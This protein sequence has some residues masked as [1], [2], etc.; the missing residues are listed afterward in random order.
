MVH[1]QA[2]AQLG[3]QFLHVGAQNKLPG[4]QNPADRL[5]HGF[6]ECIYL[7]GNVHH[8][9]WA[10]RRASIH[11]ENGCGVVLA[12]AGAATRTRRGAFGKAQGQAAFAGPPNAPAGYAGN[13]HIIGHV[14]ARHHGA[15]RDER[16]ASDDNT[17]DD[18]RIGADQSA[19]LDERLVIILGGVVRECRTVAYARW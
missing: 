9:D 5:V 18:R 15:G 17:A 12:V 13:Q 14:A 10:M 4:T 19:M 7:R 6:P 2:A 11:L 3:F 8:G 16:P 1:A